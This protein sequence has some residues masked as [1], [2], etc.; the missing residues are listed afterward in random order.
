MFRAALRL[1]GL[2]AGAAALAGVSARCLAAGPTDAEFDLMV[3]RKKAAIS[4]SG[5]TVKE[6]DIAAE[7]KKVLGPRNDQNL[8]WQTLQKDERMLNRVSVWWWTKPDG[9]EASVDEAPGATKQGKAKFGAVVRVGDALNGPPN[10][11]H[12]GFSAAL[13][14]DL[15][16]WCAVRERAVQ[17]VRRTRSNHYDFD[18]SCLPR[19]P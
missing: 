13:L 9:N 16:A 8:I 10:L 19:G 4:S 14:D 3:E 17:G 7:A 1:G 12:G 11:V 18:R 2:S 6:I 15:F 5:G